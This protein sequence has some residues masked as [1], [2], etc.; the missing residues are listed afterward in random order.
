MD[1]KSARQQPRVGVDQGHPDPGVRAR[2]LLFSPKVKR[3][4]VR[5]QL[6]IE[7]ASQ[8]SAVQI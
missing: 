6:I 7:M 3:I 8:S 2:S 4:Y 5:R 1:F